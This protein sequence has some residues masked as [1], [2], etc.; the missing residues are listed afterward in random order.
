VTVL[1]KPVTYERLYELYEE[2]DKEIMILAAKY[3]FCEDPAC[4]KNCNLDIRRKN[5]QIPKGTVTDSV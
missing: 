3:L 4:M 2:K 1:E 5:N